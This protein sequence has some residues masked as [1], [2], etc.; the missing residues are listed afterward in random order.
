MGIGGG[1]QEARFAVAIASGAVCAHCGVTIRQ[2]GVL[3]TYQVR[4]CSDTRCRETNDGAWN[5]IYRVGNLAFSTA[6]PRRFAQAIVRHVS[7][8]EQTELLTIM[9][10]A[11]GLW[12]GK[13]DVYHSPQGGD[14]T[15]R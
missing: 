5:L 7:S 8:I 12:H 1:P 15:G 2:G 10:A 9:A 4:P 14:R 13:D 11:G 6:I 3:G